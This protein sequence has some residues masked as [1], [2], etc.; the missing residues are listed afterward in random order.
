MK[1]KE[2]RFNA[3]LSVTV[4]SVR[5]SSRRQDVL[6]VRYPATLTRAQS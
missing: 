1:I 5:L 2:R 4:R 6:L 3:A